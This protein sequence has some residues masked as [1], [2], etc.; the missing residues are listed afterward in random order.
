MS[1]CHFSR[2]PHTL[3]QI[4]DAL[5]QLKKLT[6]LRLDFVNVEPI[7][8]D[9]NKQKGEE[10]EGSTMA[11]SQLFHSLQHLTLTYHHYRVGVFGF[12]RLMSSLLLV[13]GPL[14]R[15]L[16][17]KFSCGIAAQPTAVFSSLTNLLRHTIRLTTLKLELGGVAWDSVDVP[18]C[19]PLAHLSPELRQFTFGIT[20]KVGAAMLMEWL[21]Q[22]PLPTTVM[23]VKC[24][25]G[26]NV[27]T[28]DV[29]E[30]IKSNN[31][32]TTP[33][34]RS[35]CLSATAPLSDV[36]QHISGKHIVQQC[37]HFQKLQI[38]GQWYC[39]Q[40]TAPF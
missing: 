8:A 2:Q 40:Q 32:W 13:P 9:P 12:S 18:V 10:E 30:L 4:S 21:K 34:L 19:N 28:S 1:H 20:C 39:L 23:H 14:M 24:N 25:F 3:A 7:V 35:F 36:S 31:L 16:K 15:T 26:Y 33:N 38:L 29:E 17:L 27:T 11:F 5:A 37:P 22:T 6:V